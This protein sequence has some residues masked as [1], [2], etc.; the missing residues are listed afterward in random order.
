ME[1][2]ERRERAVRSVSFWGVFGSGLVIFLVC[3]ALGV[4]SLFAVDK[5]APPELAK[6]LIIVGSRR[7]V[8]PIFLPVIILVVWLVPKLLMLRAWSRERAFIAGLPFTVEHYEDVLGEG[9]WIQDDRL[10]LALEFAG[11]PP[12]EARLRELLAFDR[13]TWTPDFEGSIVH[14][15]REPGFRDKQVETNRALAVWFRRFVDGLVSGLHREA[16]LRRLAFEHP[17]REPW[18]S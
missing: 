11:A 5:W 1:Q 18:G 7:L 8:F 9:P 6:K 17:K 15:S 2:R 3:A 4:A 13:A 16:P 14:L 12:S 10:H